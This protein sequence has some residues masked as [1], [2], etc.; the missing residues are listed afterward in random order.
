MNT[1]LS[2]WKGQAK[3]LLAVLTQQKPRG[4]T[5]HDYISIRLM[6]TRYQPLLFPDG[7]VI[8]RKSCGSIIDSREKLKSLELPNDLSG[9]TFM[10][11]GC[12]EG[13]FVLEA[14]RRNADMARGC[15]MTESRIEL[16]KKVA[17]IWPF[18]SRVCFQTAKLYDITSDWSSDIV[19]CLAVCHHLHGGNHDTW[20]IISD[21]D[22]HADAFDNMLKAVE[23]VAK[24]TH[25]MT[26]WE[27]CYEYS[28]AKP[29]HIDYQL[30]GQIWVDKGI[31][32]KVTF[33]GLAQET[34][35]KDRAIYHAVK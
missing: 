6:H 31:Y 5:W 17:A 9:K 25:E 29:D 2:Y 30:L 22:K 11:I 7:V 16:A 33:K 27:Y 28:A 23:A 20:Q 12:A 13:F 10:D 32:K 1:D 19:T 4:M 8:D 35:K 34:P 18:G 26:I 3:S 21:R 14:A 24:L 15:D